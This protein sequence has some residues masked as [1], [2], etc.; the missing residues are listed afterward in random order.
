M[1]KIGHPL[2]TRDGLRKLYE[3]VLQADGELKK[4]MSEIPVFFRVTTVSSNE[5]PA[6]VHNQSRVLLLTMAHKVGIPYNYS[7]PDPLVILILLTHISSVLF[8]SPPFPGHQF[9][10]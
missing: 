5:V 1:C 2:E 7:E 4:I 10:R 8:N 3:V 9:S 6:H